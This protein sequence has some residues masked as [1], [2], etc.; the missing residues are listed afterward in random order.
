MIVW[1]LLLILIVGIF[2]AYS[3][4]NFEESQFSN[5]TGY[6]FWDI[7]KD[8]TVRHT[9]KVVSTLRK[10]SGDFKI[11]TN[12]HIPV[13]TNKE[14][15]IDIVFLHESGIYLINISKEDGWVYGRETDNEWTIATYGDKKE[16][17]KNPLTDHQN[18]IAVFSKI[19]PQIQEESIYSLAV[20]SENSSFKMIELYSKNVDVLKLSE[21]KNYWDHKDSTITKSEIETIAQSLSKL[22]KQI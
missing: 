3:I 2:I 19:F 12:L 4:Y 8:K 5:M 6:S 7:W 21:L 13:S 17:V 1:L 18:I 16:A 11:L 22:I 15:I 10:A 14:K 9:Y 20:F